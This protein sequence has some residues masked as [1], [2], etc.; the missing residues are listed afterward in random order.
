MADEPQ[1][2]KP[3]VNDLRVLIVDDEMYA[4]MGIKDA[5]DWQGL[6]VTDVC[7][8]FNM[9]EAVKILERQPVDVMICDIEMPKGTGIELLEWVNERSL[10]MET[11]F[12][13]A[14]GD[15]RF[16]QRAIQLSSF[17]YIMKPVEFGVL[18]QTIRKALDT[19]QKKKAELALTEQYKPYYELWNKKKTLLSEKFWYDLLA[20]RIVVGPGDEERLPAEYGIAMQ[21]DAKLLP[22]VVSVENWKRELS[23]RD[24]EVMEYAIRQSVSEMVVA[25][26]SGE[27]VQTKH[28][29]TVALLYVSP[30][31]EGTLREV[32]GERCGRYIEACSTY[33]NC[34]VSC[35]I[36]EPVL[37]RE[38]TPMYKA[39]LALEYN[40][41]SESNQLNWLSKQEAEPGADPRLPDFGA[42]TLLLENGKAE[43]LG[44]RLSTSLRELAAD[45]RFGASVLQAY[46]LGFLQMVYYLLQKKGLSAYR[47]LQDAGVPAEA[48]PRTLEQMEDWGIRIIRT[49]HRYLFQEESTIERLCAYISEHLAENITREMLAE[50]VYLNSAYLSRLFKKEKGMSITDYLLQE[51][52]RI[53]RDLI[54]SSTL[55]ISDIAQSVGFS[56]FSYFA[57]MFK[58]VHNVNPQQLRKLSGCP[59]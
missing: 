17:D 11:I 37:L 57:K 34:S 15:F 28:G 51:R 56:N 35:Y 44:A 48:S 8:A 19:V 26:S 55:P 27:V 43:E 1:R 46:Y 7:E 54:E 40:N 33:L 20:E 13:T 25:D 5:I 50:H 16:M 12:L 58:K 22:V 59:G 24:E 2:I 38:L 6:G 14:H 21:A 32:V 29:V 18:E 36:G 9:R 10:R 53:A 41:L 23:T 45:R 4:V 39:L 49:V 52:M 3:E 42:W 47:L 30:D 31:E